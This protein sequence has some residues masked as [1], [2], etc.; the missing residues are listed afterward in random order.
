MFL[1][2]LL[3]SVMLTAQISRPGSSMDGKVSEFTKMVT[4]C[5]NGQ[6]VD[7]MKLK[8]LYYE[9]NCSLIQPQAEALDP[10][11]VNIR[12]DI[13]GS[14]VFP[15]TQTLSDATF[16]KYATVVQEYLKCAGK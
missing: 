11:I 6:R 2:A 16:K 10:E 13:C 7:K 3:T 1:V 5:N 15:T 14:S 9:I 4:A 8:S 12:E